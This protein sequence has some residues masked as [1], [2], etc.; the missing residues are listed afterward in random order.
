[1]SNLS[2]LS[3][4][5]QNKSQQE[6]SRGAQNPNPPIKIW[7]KNGHHDVIFKDI[8]IQISGLGAPNY[9]SYYVS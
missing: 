2:G 1:M 9:L 3:K 4:F 7:H 6:G 8:S 5:V